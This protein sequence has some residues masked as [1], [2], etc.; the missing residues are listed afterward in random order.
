MTSNELR[1]GF[2]EYF[3]GQGHT[4]VPSSLLI[5]AQDPTLL[6][7]NAGMVQF[8]GV[9]LGEEKRSYCRAVSSQKCMRAGGKHNDLENVGRT[10]RHHTFF[11][12]LGNFSFGDYFKAEAAA[13]AW[14]LLVKRWGLPKDHLWI[15]VYQ[16]D[17]EAHEFWRKIGISTDRIKRMGEKDNF[18]QMG[19][20]GPCGP[21][22]EVLYDQGPKVWPPGHQ[23]QGVGCDCDRY[24]EIWNLVFMQYTRDKEGKLN[25][26]PKPSIDTGMGLERVTAV[27][28]GVPSNYDTDLFVPLFSALSGMT[29]HDLTKIRQGMAGRVIVDHIRAITFLISD[30]VLPSNEGRGYV[31]RRIIRRAAR[32][33]KELGLDDPFLYKLSAHVVELM[34]S[35]YPELEKSRNL[36]SQV[37]CGEE[38]RFRKTLVEGM[39]RWKEVMRRVRGGG[40]RIIPGQEAFRLYD[41]YGFPLD[42]AT[43]MAEESGLKVD[44]AG[45]HAAME[46]QRER[47]RRSWVV[48]EVA[49]Y[50]QELS[51]R[52]GLTEFMGYQKLSEEVRL[53]GILK[54]G[55]LVQKAQAGDLVELL[56]DQTPF[57]GE[58]GGQIGDQGLLKHPSAL[59]EITNTIKPIPGLFV[60]QGKVTHGEIAE[61]ETYLAVVNS[62]AR[63]GAS[64]NH[65]A[66]HILHS[67]LREV[68]GEHVKQAGSLVAPDRLRFDF[69]HFAA[70]S[71]QE[72][73]RI[74]VMANERVRGDYPVESKVMGF[75]EAVRSG[76]LAFFD[77]KYGDQVRVVRIG[78]FSKELCGGTHCRE[79]GEVGIVRLIQESSIAAGMRRIEAVTGEA[80][81]LSVKKQEEDLQELARMLKVQPFEVVEKTRKTLAMLREWEKELERH[82][83]RSVAAH[84]EDILSEVK[85]VDSV[86]VLI[87]RQDGLD[88]KELRTFAD[89]I[90]DR[91][92]SG[93]ILLGSVK[94]EKVSLLMMVTKELS[95]RFHAGEILKEVA[96]VIGGTGGGRPEMAQG[97]GKEAERLDDALSK[98]WEFIKSKR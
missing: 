72:L 7:T 61:G 81:Y 94:D 40:N 60:H 59:V 57:Y 24:L 34:K 41:T 46:E 87:R 65:T 78:D 68:L 42:I 16:D 55:R 22:S 97:G 54:D 95:G 8:K 38:E 27:S 31:L 6:F 67:V 26:L 21:C 90:R 62:S 92:Q 2:L 29:Q 49:P 14:E 36:V 48:K 91:L 30:G 89:S 58:S 35:A 66:T 52:F 96:A 45:F 79:T 84:A 43:D 18:W 74:E 13:Y 98:G 32:Y 17:D 63:Q 4:L 88:Q 10:A 51:K 69:S 19:D 70:L 3:A 64:N 5:P 53:L 47:A 85:E 28:Q 76:A 23:C 9:F 73:R 75:Q 1:Q 37:A 86:K 83:S 11:E 25:P 77:D 33:G 44:E 50:Y 82:K 93:V 12:M 56:F 71:Q 39:D 80:A 15:T 20:T